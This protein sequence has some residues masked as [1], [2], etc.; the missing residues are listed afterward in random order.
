[1]SW[2]GPATWFSLDARDIV[3]PGTNFPVRSA[4][5]LGRGRPTRRTRW[6]QRSAL[7]NWPMGRMGKPRRS[8]EVCRGLCPR[9]GVPTAVRPLRA[10]RRRP[11]A[12]VTEIPKGGWEAHATGPVLASSPPRRQFVHRT[13]QIPAPRGPELVA[14][15]HLKAGLNVFQNLKTSRCTQPEFLGL[16][17]TDSS[18]CRVHKRRHAFIN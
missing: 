4:G 3:G 11:Q 1:M 12:A 7:G 6:S 13:P 9:A 8:P 18:A 16:P 10:L 5:H 17:D 2:Q 15:A 14:S